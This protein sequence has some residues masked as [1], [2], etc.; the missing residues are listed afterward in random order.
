MSVEA[1]FEVKSCSAGMATYSKGNRAV[2]P[3]D[4]DF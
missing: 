3:P 1:V 2:A 4:P